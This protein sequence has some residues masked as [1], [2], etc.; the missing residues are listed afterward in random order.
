MLK[1]DCNISLVCESIESLPER[2]FD[3]GIFACGYEKRSR[4]FSEK[5]QGNKFKH[6]ILLGFDTHKD[7]PT[8]IENEAVF[9]KIYNESPVLIP[10]NDSDAV[11]KIISKVLKYFDSSKKCQVFIDY[12]SMSRT[13]YTHLLFLFKYIKLDVKVNIECIFGY[14]GGL[15]T[16][17]SVHRTIRN[18]YSLPGCEGVPRTTKGTLAL[19]GLGYDSLAIASVLDQLEPSKIIAFYAED[20]KI[21]GAPLRVIEENKILLNTM[22]IQSFR[23]D[24]LDVEGVF[25]V[26]SEIVMPYIDD[27]SINIIPLGPK[28]HTLA[29]VL[30][31]QKFPE[32]SC[33]Y[34][35]GE[36][37]I[38]YD[39]DASG[40]TSIYKIDYISPRI[41]EL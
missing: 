39:V 28:T 20:E 6:V 9:R 34:I 10:S 40:C 33:L 15:Y 16:Q 31:S 29:C 21:K 27:W 35:N 7:H 1:S 14:V 24:Y 3:I 37:K 13:W 32:I 18:I 5:M 4:F 36:S 2:T 12:S 26:L 8:R 17:K 23:L 22:D 30:L 11:I 38:P 19:L 41:S 25:R